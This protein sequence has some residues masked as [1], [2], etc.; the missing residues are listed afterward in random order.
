MTR[1]PALEC[2][3]RSFGLSPA[4]SPFHVE[5]LR[6]RL[7]VRT[8]LRELGESAAVVRSSQTVGSVRPAEDLLSR[9]RSA[10]VWTV[11]FHVELNGG[12]H[13]YIHIGALS[14]GQ[15]MST[16]SPEAL[17]AIC[18]YRAVSSR[19]APATHVLLLHRMR[20]IHSRARVMHRPAGYAQRSL[21]YPQARFGSRRVVHRRV[22]EFVGS[23]W[24]GLLLE[25]WRRRD[26]RWV[27][28]TV[29]QVRSRSWT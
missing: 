22:Q 20:V 1:R 29:R 15:R 18:C 27:R 26:D 9:S 16:L 2:A 21:S 7:R 19:P 25:G 5:H 11:R 12:E 8:S 13:S 6:K 17:V 28:M 3:L 14:C 10:E 24:G 23:A 4:S